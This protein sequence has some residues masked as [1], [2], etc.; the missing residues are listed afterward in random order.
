ML[1]DDFQSI[2]IS[3]GVSFGWAIEAI[4]GSSFKIDISYFSPQ[5]NYAN[6]LESLNQ[7][8]ETNL[9]LSQDVVNHM[10]EKSRFYTRNID[11]ILRND[12]PESKLLDYILK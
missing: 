8:Y 2:N 11:S 6:T 7:F 4:I 12:K 1:L 10:S 3:F 9:I 5:I